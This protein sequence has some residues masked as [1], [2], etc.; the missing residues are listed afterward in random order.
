MEM[1]WLL[2]QTHLRKEQVVNSATYGHRECVGEGEGYGGEKMVQFQILQ[3]DGI[4]SLQVTETQLT[5]F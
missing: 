4:F 2:R 3:E 5:S 1:L